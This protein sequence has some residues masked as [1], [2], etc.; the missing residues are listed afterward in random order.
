[1]DEATE[2]NRKKGRMKTKGR[3]RKFLKATITPLIDATCMLNVDVQKHS[4]SLMQA[5]TKLSQ[6]QPNH[7]TFV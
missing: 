1:M 2:E 6:A 7:V 5:H 4:N 3:R